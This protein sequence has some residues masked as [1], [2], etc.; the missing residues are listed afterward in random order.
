MDT[1][2]EIWGLHLNEQ[3]LRLLQNAKMV[4][5]TQHM[6]VNIFHVL[7]VALTDT[8]LSVYR[9][10][11]DIF[12]DAGLLSEDVLGKDVRIK[13]LILEVQTQMANDTLSSNLD[14]CRLACMETALERQVHIS[15]TLIIEQIIDKS[16]R[17]RRILQ[18]EQLL[19]SMRAALQDREKSSGPALQRTP[20]GPLNAQEAR[21]VLERVAVVSSTREDPGGSFLTRLDEAL[22]RNT[23]D[24]L[25]GTLT[26]MLSEGRQK[27]L[28]LCGQHGSVFDQGK[29][30]KI[31][32]Y[33]LAAK[34]EERGTAQSVLLGGYQLWQLSL[35]TLRALYAAN[36]R[37]HPVLALKH[38]KR[39]ARVK[40]AVLLLTELETVSTRSSVDRGIKDQ[41]TNLDD[42]CVVGCYKYYD[43][44]PHEQELLL[45]MS[46][47][48]VSIVY[49]DRQ[50]DLSQLQQLQQWIEEYYRQQHPGQPMSLAPG[51]LESLLYLEP[52]IWMCKQRKAFPS[53]SLDVL[54]GCLA[55]LKEPLSLQSQAREAL[56]ALQELLDTESQETPERVRLRFQEI[57][58]QARE[59]MHELIRSPVPEIRQGKVVITR[60]LIEAQ[61]FNRS[62]CEFHFPGHFPW[63]TR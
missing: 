8:T 27:L 54:D 10:F 3:A 43:R 47:E 37:F 32:A 42:T 23:F 22:H 45:G 39:E 61:I 25:L 34:G 14:M 36:P 5:D 18:R 20:S 30:E 21:E 40:Q 29:L 59:H 7:F 53:L 46:R 12:K 24:E 55:A 16:Y 31:L 17:V 63:A 57:L 1:L 2:L 6:N 58:R 62:V 19:L 44:R 13:G 56:S 35:H 38:L 48:D 15:D 26:R 28:V 49:P 9:K 11:T 33:R 41:L 60:A 4:A 50:P 51:A 52:G